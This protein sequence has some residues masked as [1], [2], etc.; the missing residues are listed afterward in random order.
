LLAGLAA[1]DV[2]SIGFH[3]G[4]PDADGDEAHEPCGWCDVC[5]E[6]RAAEGG[7]NEASEARI[8][9]RLIC[10]ECFDSIRLLARRR[11]Q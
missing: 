3:E 10:S 9:I 4:E 1:D 5:E 11:M 7:W 2:Q 8:E 6:V